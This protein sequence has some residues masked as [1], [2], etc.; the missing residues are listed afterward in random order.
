MKQYTEGLR[1]KW[2]GAM[3]EFL[4]AA[5]EYAKNAKDGGWLA[6]EMLKDATIIPSKSQTMELA[7]KAQQPEPESE[8]AAIKRIAVALVQGAIERHR[9]FGLPLPE[10]DEVEQSLLAKAKENGGCLE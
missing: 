4:L 9:F 1:E 10:A 3:E 8:Q 5:I 6:Y 7:L 2:Y